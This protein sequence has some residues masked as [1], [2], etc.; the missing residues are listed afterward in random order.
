[1]KG[2]N[3]QKHYPHSLNGSG[4]AVD[5]LIIALLEYYYNEKE[6]KLFL[7]KVLQRYFF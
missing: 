2:S 4:L 1:V 3:G 6:N 5:R 7:P